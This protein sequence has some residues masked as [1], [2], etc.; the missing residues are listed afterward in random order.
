[1]RPGPAIR[2]NA[3]GTDIVVEPELDRSVASNPPSTRDSVADAVSLLLDEPCA[4]LLTGS[5]THALEAAA[6]LTGVGPGDEVIVPAFTFP[7]TAAAFL[8][9]GADV[10]FADIDPTTGNLDPDS[11]TERLGDRTRVV[12]A[13]HYAGVAADVVRIGRSADDAG[14]ILVEDAAHGVHARLAGTPLGR[15]GALAAL[16][17]HRTKNLTAGDGGALVVNDP[18][19]VAAARVAVDK[20]TNRADFDAGRVG[21]YEWT[22]LGSAW[23]LPDAALPILAASLANTEHIQRARHHVWASYSIGLSEWADRHGVTLPSVPSDAEHPAHIFWMTLPE[24]T[25]RDQFVARCSDGGVEVARHFGSLPDSPYGRTITR[26][27]DRCPTASRF[28]QQLVRLPLHHELTD[29]EVERVI[30]VVVSALR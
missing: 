14:A 5:C 13:M 29:A 20:G 6:L 22:G 1:V 28:A 7:S 26:P 3:S 18:A 21:S 8:L 24:G 23:H 12:V 11:V 30:D 27:T 4:L 10:R 17:F 9:R 2:L 16:S 19:L 15:F 25:P